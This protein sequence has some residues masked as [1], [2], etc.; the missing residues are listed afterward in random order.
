MTRNK[1][2]HQDAENKLLQHEPRNGE[3]A[4]L[5]RLNISKYCRLRIH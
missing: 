1:T 3:K 4:Y 5:M 2:G